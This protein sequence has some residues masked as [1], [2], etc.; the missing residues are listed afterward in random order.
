[1]VLK[2]LRKQY[3]ED[4]ETVKI[5]QSRAVD[6]EHYDVRITAIALL[7]EEFRNNSEVQ[8]FLDNL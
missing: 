8:E 7:K 6:D 3:K 2:L 1:M 5:L 4:P